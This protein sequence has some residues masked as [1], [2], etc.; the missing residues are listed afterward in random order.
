MAENKMQHRDHIQKAL[1]RWDQLPQGVRDAFYDNLRTEAI[2]WL[3]LWRICKR[4]E[5]KY[6]ID[7]M[8][9]LREE[10]EK[11]AFALGQ[12]LAQKFE[13]H[14]IKDV[15]EAYFARFEGRRGHR[16]WFELSDE[17]LH[18]WVLECPFRK[19]FLE[20]GSSDEEIKEMAPYFCLPWD[21]VIVKGFNP[22]LECCT[23][24]S[25]ILRGDD[26]CT[27]IIEDHGGKAQPIPEYG[28]R[29]PEDFD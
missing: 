27:Y 12:Q 2:G 15:Y 29:S 9:I 24:P 19:I 5:K 20:L 28:V 6:N 8:N 3:Q 23:P 16:V 13:E 11:M 7:V 1:E 4:I 10:R 22:K 14:G 25:N 18:Y 17:R 21:V 26:H